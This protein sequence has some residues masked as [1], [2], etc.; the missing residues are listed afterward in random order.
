MLQD[1]ERIEVVSELLHHS[2]IRVT[3]QVYAYLNPEHIR[4]AVD[5][6]GT[7]GGF[8]TQFVTLEGKKKSERS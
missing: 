3:K 7:N 2:S 1:G 4:G 6:L 8:V 5:R